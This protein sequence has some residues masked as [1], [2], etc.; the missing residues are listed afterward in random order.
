[1]FTDTAVLVERNLLTVK[2][3]PTLLIS[4]T[5]QPLMFVFLFAYVFG[6]TFGGGSYREFLMAGI[7]TQTVVFNAAFTTVGL[8]NDTSDGIVDRLRSLPMSRLGVISGR[9]TSDM[10]LGIVGLAVMVACGLAIGWRVHGSAV[11]AA[12]AFG[13]IGLF[14]L[15]MAWVGAVTG[16][17]APNVEAAQSIGF[18]W[19][20]PVT[21]LS[22]AFISAQ[23]LPGPLRAIAEWN[24]VTAV[25]TAC[26]QLFGN[27]APP[28]FPPA[29]GW[30]AD[31]AVG[32]SVGSALLILAVCIPVSLILYRRSANR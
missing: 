29:T 3:I 21:F 4:A 16:L 26:R 30:V 11:D 32:Y 6:A 7:F 20:F 15:A 8:A 14:A 17:A 13:I 10:V 22:S 27:D 19:M 24:P 5:I 28:D 1:M 12:I 31:H 9:V 18:L 25:A 23:S 2:R